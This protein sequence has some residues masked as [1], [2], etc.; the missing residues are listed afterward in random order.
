MRHA[1][2]QFSV[3]YESIHTEYGHDI[4]VVTEDAAKIIFLKILGGAGADP[5]EAALRQAIGVENEFVQLNKEEQERLKDIANEVAKSPDV[6]LCHSEL[7]QGLV[8]M[9]IEDAEDPVVSAFYTFIFHECSWT[10][11]A[12]LGYD[13]SFQLPERRMFVLVKDVNSPSLV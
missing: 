7:V 10:L 12:I 2:A 5:N 3:R 6:L 9:P 4:N 1:F 13:D 11:T 8:D